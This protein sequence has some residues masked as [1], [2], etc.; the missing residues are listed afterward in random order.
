[1]GY[2][3]KRNRTGRKRTQRG[4][5]ASGASGFMDQLV[6]TVDQQFNNVFNSP[7]GGNTIKPLM[8]QQGGRRRKHRRQKGGY[9]AQ[10]INNAI[11]PLTLFA[12][13]KQ[14]HTS[15][16]SSANN[17]ASRTFKRRR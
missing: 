4:G 2:S 1:M 5:S 8:M 13:N 12:L 9:W 11:V 6:G 3:R 16:R 17:G 10:V 15:K 14:A 7:N